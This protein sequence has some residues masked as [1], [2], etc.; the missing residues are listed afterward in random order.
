MC[1]RDSVETTWLMSM[2]LLGS[3]ALFMVYILLFARDGLKKLLRH[4]R[5]LLT[6]RDSPCSA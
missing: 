5:H 2:R 1:I 3:G 4:P 6:G